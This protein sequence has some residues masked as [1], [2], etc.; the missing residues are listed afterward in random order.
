MYVI[1]GT[2][3]MKFLK[4]ILDRVK[5]FEYKAT[6]EHWDKRIAK[7]NVALAAGE[8]VFI[9]F[10]CGQKHHH[11]YR[12]DTEYIERIKTPEGVKRTV[13]TPTCYA[14][15]LGEK[16]ILLKD[17]PVQPDFQNDLFII[18]HDMTRA[19]ANWL[20]QYIH[21]RVYIVVTKEGFEIKKMTEVP[22]REEL[23][24]GDE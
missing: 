3:K 21:T 19:L 15:P 16:V 23:E 8:D 22:T 11:T 14:V 5:L 7:A 4:Q 9:S 24:K 6:G 17:V 20:M 18:D 2:I 1:A 13:T 10:L 12:V